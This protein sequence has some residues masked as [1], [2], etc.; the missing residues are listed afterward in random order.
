MMLNNVTDSNAQGN[1]ILS[2][3]KNL[4]IWLLLELP[5]SFATLR[6]TSEGLRLALS[7]S[8]G[9]TGP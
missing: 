5:R 3:A 6:M 8:E 2:E 1:V 4:R 7:V 9:M